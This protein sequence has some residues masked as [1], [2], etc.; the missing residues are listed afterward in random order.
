MKP[1]ASLK[2]TAFQRSYP[3]AVSC[4]RRVRA[5][6]ASFTD[7]YPRSDDLVLVASELSANAVQHSGSGAPGS[8][9]TVRAHLYHG[10]Y[11]WLEVED[12]G[13]PWV[14]QEP[15]DERGR[16]LTVVA[17]LAGTG[18]W[19]VEDTSSGKRVVWVRLGWT[20]PE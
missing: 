19:G 1:A 4:L 18:N 12:Q 15:G 3:G 13:G 14:A 8:E 9:F 17:A 16:G 2:V 7:G 20:D 5:E 11:A 6:L 10:D